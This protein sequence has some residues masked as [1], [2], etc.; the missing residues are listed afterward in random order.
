MSYLGAALG[1]RVSEVDDFKIV[2]KFDFE[3]LQNCKKSSILRYFKINF[4]QVAKGR[5]TQNGQFH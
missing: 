5:G 1:Q 4:V 2:K 3:V